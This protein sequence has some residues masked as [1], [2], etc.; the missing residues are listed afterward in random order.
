MKDITRAKK[1][2]EK[3]ISNTD[4]RISLTSKAAETLSQWATHSVL[5]T[6]YSLFSV[7]QMRNC[8]SLALVIVLASSLNPVLEKCAAWFPWVCDPLF[9]NLTLNSFSTKLSYLWYLG[10]SNSRMGGRA[11]RYQ[12]CGPSTSLNSETSSFQLKTF[13][14][15]RS[16]SYA[17]I[18]FQSYR[19]SCE[20]F[21]ST[22]H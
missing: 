5:K 20:H 1:K 16:L 17:V 12:A 6:Y 4:I 8:S 22:H 2:K 21:L 14:W 9:F 15:P 19:T 11:F 13:R 7:T 18:G 3:E 10:A